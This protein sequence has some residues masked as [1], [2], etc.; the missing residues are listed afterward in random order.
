M[1]EMSLC[2]GIVGIIEDA[3]ERQTFARVR[4]VTLELGRLGHV[5]PQAMLFCFEAASRGT[6]ADGAELVIRLTDGAAWCFDCEA[7]VPLDSRLSPCPTCGGGRLQV[8]AG[9]ELR[10]AE[11][12][13]D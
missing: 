8:T 5:L 12:E 1:H 7:T 6:L 4:S 11:I 9:E 13:V 3:A 2:Q 10:V